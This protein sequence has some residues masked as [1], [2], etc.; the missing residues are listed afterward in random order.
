MI[1]A[2]NRG[3]TNASIVLRWEMLEVASVTSSTAFD[4]RDVW[5]KKT[6]HSALVEG[7]TT[8]VGPHDIQIFKLSKPAA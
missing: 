2:L 3:D 4:V 6:L 5:A 8:V 1:A 7:F